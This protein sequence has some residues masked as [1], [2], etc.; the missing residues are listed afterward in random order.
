MHIFVHKYL[1]PFLIIL[2]GCIP[3]NRK[4]GANDVRLWRLLR[5]IAQVFCRELVAIYVPTSNVRGL[6]L[7]ASWQALDMP[8]LLLIIF[9]FFLFHWNKSVIKSS[10]FLLA[11]A[12]IFLSFLSIFKL[13]SSAMFS[14]ITHIQICQNLSLKL[15]SL[16]SRLIPTSDLPSASSKSLCLYGQYHTSSSSMDLWLI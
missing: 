13:L 1:F 7:I 11:N 15:I 4:S 3:R 8:A 6:C 2:L 14:V 10:C 16:I 5:N 12:A 9:I